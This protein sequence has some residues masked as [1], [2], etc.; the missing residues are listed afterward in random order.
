M[1]ID[2]A[3]ARW[4][5]HRHRAV[6]RLQYLRV[7]GT[8]AHPLGI[9]DAGSSHGHGVPA[10]SAAG[11]GAYGGYD[12][13]SV[14]LCNVVEAADLGVTAPGADDGHVGGAWRSGRHVDDERLGVQEVDVG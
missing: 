1:H 14:W 10:V 4:H 13:L 11:R 5:R 12:Q 7:G 8:E 2:L 6:E 3:G 9:A